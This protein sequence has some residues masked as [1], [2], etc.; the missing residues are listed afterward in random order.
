M[1]STVV[2]LVVRLAE[3]WGTRVLSRAARPP[4]K[5]QLFKTMRGDQGQ[6]SVMPGVNALLPGLD[7]TLAVTEDLRA[8]F[9]ALS[10]QG[11]ARR[12]AG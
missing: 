5:R 7:G 2:G 6:S 12:S 10:R 4:H 3:G 8:T 9:E 1:V 11:T